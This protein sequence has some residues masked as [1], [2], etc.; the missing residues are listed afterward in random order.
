M[1]TFETRLQGG[2]QNSLGNTIEV[3]NEVLAE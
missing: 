3:V 1:K 2:P